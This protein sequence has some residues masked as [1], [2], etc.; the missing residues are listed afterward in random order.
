[1]TILYPKGE[2]LF[3]RAAASHRQESFRVGIF[4]SDDLAPMNRLQTYGYILF[5][6]LSIVSGMLLYSG[7]AWPNSR[8]PAAPGN[9]KT[10]HLS[11][12]YTVVDMGEIDQGKDSEATFYI[13][14]KGNAALMIDNL[15]VSDSAAVLELTANVV[16]PSEEAILRCV[17]DTSN[18]Q[19]RII[20][21]ITF[22][23]NDPEH[24]AT[25]LQATGVIRPLLGLE[26]P[27]IFAGQIGK[28]APF[29]KTVALNG[30]LVREGKCD[31]LKVYVNSPFIQAT[32]VKKRHGD[33]ITPMLHILVP[34]D[35]KA[36]TFK[37]V[38]R[39]VSENPAAEASLVVAG[40]KLG[41]IQVK[42]DRLAFFSP[43]GADPGSRT[44]VLE[45]QKVFHIKEIQDLSGLLSLSVQT[46]RP[47]K[48]YE[49][50]AAIKK[51][52]LKGNSFLGLVQVHTDLE[53]H[54][55][56]DL[57]VLIGVNQ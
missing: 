26:T 8:R 36:G 32:I 5:L 21:H 39:V 43:K 57:P 3:N 29:S 12:P 15:T 30:T 54:P 51:G 9:Q 22:H 1:M 47:G 38:I 7:P 23:S 55:L 17:L 56:I 50:T 28:E 46:V 33:K 4:A 20:I 52:M 13:Q 25:T 10:P 45:S 53:E 41:V 34:A 24:P 18:M 6:C 19:G 42:P 48:C 35:M 37:E 16:R 27:L 14:N 49:I 40:Q 31:G 11:M 44:V 2:W